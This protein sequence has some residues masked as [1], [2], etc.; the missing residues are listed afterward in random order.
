MVLV[1]CE[2]AMPEMLTELEMLLEARG[3]APDRGEVSLVTAGER[4]EGEC[5]MY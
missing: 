2:A 4:G 3:W 5:T 1:W